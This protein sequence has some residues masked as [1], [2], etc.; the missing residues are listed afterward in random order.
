MPAALRIVLSEHR[1]IEAVLD[2][3]G[4]S[5]DCIRAAHLVRVP[6]VFRA[7]LQY[8]DL[9]AERLYRSRR[10]PPEM[11]SELRTEVAWARHTKG[12]TED[13][14]CTATSASRT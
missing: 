14:K 1:S 2:A 10:S 3:L 7:L 5:V 11:N 13:E 8:I 12:K 6:R 4:F 9:F